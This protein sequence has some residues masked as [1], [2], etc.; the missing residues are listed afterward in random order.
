MHE[1]DTHFWYQK[2]LPQYLTYWESFCAQVSLH[3]QSNLLSVIVDCLIPCCSY[4][5]MFL[6]DV[7]YILSFVFGAWDHISWLYLFNYHRPRVIGAKKGEKAVTSTPY[8]VLTDSERHRTRYIAS[9]VL[10]FLCHST[11]YSVVL[12]RVT[13]NWMVLT[14]WVT[15]CLF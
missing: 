14:L 3:C 11:W 2:V 8:D 7:T 6:Y 10:L 9:Y 5:S 1:Y 15:S 12:I 4:C 13:C